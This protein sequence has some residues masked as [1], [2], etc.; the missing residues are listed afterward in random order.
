MIIEGLK[1]TILGYVDS[2]KDPLDVIFG[3]ED[4]KE[5]ILTSILADHHVLIEGPPGVGKTTLAKYLASILPPV[6]AVKGCPFHCDPGKLVCP[7]CI[8]KS[9]EGNLEVEKVEGARRFVRI[10]GS[11]D[12]TAEDLLGDIDPTKAFK[13]GP[14]DYRAFTP[15]K[16]LKGNRGIVFFDELN[17]VPEK[18]QNALLQVLEERIATI[19]PYDVD[20]A[21]NFIMLATMNPREHAGVEELSD[22][23]LDRFDIVRMGYPETPERER[24]I[25][26]KYGLKTEGIEIP[27]EAID[28]IV[29]LVRATREEPWDKELDQGASARAGLSLYEKVQTIAL[30]QKR[31][32][33]TIDDVRSMAV[34]SMGS[35][36]KPSPESKFYDD[37]L[38]LIQEISEGILGG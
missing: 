6:N 29:K 26:V 34:S 7:L 27:D 16:L 2:G 21:S 32:T 35:R 31:K 11:P 10:Q 5:K 18:L 4:A 22:V 24:Q 38:G 19:G 8:T 37:P 9:K 13:F 15:G 20:Y 14:H 1:E 28:S 23:L 36:I 30:L 25:L 17:R 12:L 3:Q 33:A